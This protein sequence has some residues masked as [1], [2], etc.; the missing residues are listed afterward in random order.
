[1]VLPLFYICSC[2]TIGY[3]A[4]TSFPNEKILKKYDNFRNIT[5]YKHKAFTEIGSINYS[6]IEIY[7]IESQ[8]ATYMRLKFLYRGSNWIFFENAY[9]VN[10]EQERMSFYFRPDNLKS[11][12][13]S[14][15]SLR[16]L[17]DIRLSDDKAKE[18]I[19]IINGNNVKLRLSGE[20]YREYSLRK[21]QIKGL[22]EIYDFYILNKSNK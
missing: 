5:F 8:S 9:I 3:K 12:V 1:M 21:R 7:V 14:G 15:N 2:S 20:K 18:L 16:E 13:I 10:S 19:N 6:P 4:I 22:Q 11:D 17:A